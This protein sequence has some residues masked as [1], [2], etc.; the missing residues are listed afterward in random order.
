MK[1][2]NVQKRSRINCCIK[3]HYYLRNAFLEYQNAFIINLY[4]IETVYFR[5]KHGE[6]TYRSIYLWLN[7]DLMIIQANNFEKLWGKWQVL[8]QE[9]N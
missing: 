8:Y 2:Y 1:F 6:I 4:I 5:R 7:Q 9:I 3:G